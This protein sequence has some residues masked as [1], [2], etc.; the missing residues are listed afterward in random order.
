MATVIGIFENQYKKGE[1]L[2]IVKPGTQSRTFTHVNDTVR[3]C[4][5]A[6]KLNKKR[7]LQYFS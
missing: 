5:D 7:S 6:W 4:Y 3:V 2:T 1:P